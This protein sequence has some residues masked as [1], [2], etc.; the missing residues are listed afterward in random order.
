MHATRTT[1]QRNAALKGAMGDRLDPSLELPAPT[2][3]FRERGPDHNNP[4]RGW[5]MR[6]Q[7]IALTGTQPTT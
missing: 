7:A 2:A 3:T 4:V 6:L 5:R 1:A